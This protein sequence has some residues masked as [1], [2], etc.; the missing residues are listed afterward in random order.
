MN[1]VEEI[2]KEIKQ[3]ERNVNQLKKELKTIQMNCVHDFKTKDTIQECS[4]C[5]LIE[6]LS[7]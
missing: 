3:L 1:R 2:A 6:S 5:H 7:W 4:K